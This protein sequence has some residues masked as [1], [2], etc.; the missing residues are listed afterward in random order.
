MKKMV[1]VLLI[2]CLALPA[3]GQNGLRINVKIKGDAELL[4][5]VN[6][7]LN[8]ELRSLGDVSITEEN[9]HFNIY[10]TAMEIEDESGQGTGV[11]TV[12]YIVTSRLSP[13]VYRW[14]EEK[15]N[16]G[17]P[18]DEWEKTWGNLGFLERY[19]DFIIG[20]ED[21]RGLFEGLV[22]QLDTKVFEKYRR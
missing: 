3:Y 8:R 18:K 17:I 15:G 4:D 21:L 16:R 12:S 11:I 10:M 7:F 9:P 19:G 2:F 5:E 22:V 1:A 20:K 6:S 14:L 13:E